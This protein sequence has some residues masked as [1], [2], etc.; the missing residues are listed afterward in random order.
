MGLD[1]WLG[2]G[3]KAWMPQPSSTQEALLGP[4]TRKEGSRNREACWG[5]HWEWTPPH[6]TWK[7]D[8]LDA[9]NRHDLWLCSFL[10]RG[11]LQER[12]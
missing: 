2:L 10:L 8:Y 5:F 12:H 6:V 9:E 4:V 1:E 11:L 3:G 7:H